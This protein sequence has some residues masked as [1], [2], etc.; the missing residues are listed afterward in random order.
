L[1]ELTFARMGGKE[2]DAPIPAVRAATIGRLNRPTAD[3]HGH[4]AGR[5]AS[6]KAGDQN[7]CDGAVTICA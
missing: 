6:R 7:P 4:A 1:G 3:L 5:A 2:E